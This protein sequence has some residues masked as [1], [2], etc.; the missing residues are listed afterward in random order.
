MEVMGERGEAGLLGMSDSLEGREKKYR[1][2]GSH[3]GFRT[4]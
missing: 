2:Q 4:V 3:M 1:E